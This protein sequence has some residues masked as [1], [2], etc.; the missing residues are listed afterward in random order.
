[1]AAYIIAQVDINDAERYQEYIKKVPIS[2][3]Q[4]GGQFIARG[5]SA[6]VLEGSKPL[7]QRLVIIQFESLERAKAWWSSE[8]YR[9]A[10]ALRQET[11]DGT[12]FLVDGV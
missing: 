11:S 9:E 3:A 1:M 7:P 5:G 6:E 8:E 10:K 2:L 12:L 4:Y